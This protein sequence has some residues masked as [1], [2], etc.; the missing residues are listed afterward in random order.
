MTSNIFLD[1]SCTICWLLCEDKPLDHKEK[2][3]GKG[4]SIVGKIE[5]KKQTTK[6]KEE[7]KTFFFHHIFLIVI[8]ELTLHYRGNNVEKLLSCTLF[9]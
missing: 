4:R 3:L 6:K 5:E 7:K 9:L 8:S 2:E 1:P